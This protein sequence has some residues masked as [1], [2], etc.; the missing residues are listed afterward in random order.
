MVRVLFQHRTVGVAIFTIPTTLEEES[1]L[2]EREERAAR[3]WLVRPQLGAHKRD[4]KH[5]A[6]FTISRF[7][8][9]ALNWM[10]K[11]R[12]QLNTNAKTEKNSLRRLNTS[13]IK[14]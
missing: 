14:N 12:T 6:E 7:T 5:Q 11:L 13:I 1:T 8:K 10:Q 9:S 4:L 2:T 3:A